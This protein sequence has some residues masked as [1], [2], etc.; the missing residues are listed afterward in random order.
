VLQALFSSRVRVRAL[1]IFLLNPDTS[2]HT[3]ALAQTVGA[4]YSAVW[5]ELN[6]LEQAGLLLSESSAHTKAYRVNPRCPILP[7]LRAMILKTVGAGDTLRQAFTDLGA[8][9]TAFI[10][11]SFAAGDPDRQSDLDVMMIGNVKLTRLAPVFARL[12]KDLGRAVNYVCYTPEEWTE[13]QRAWE[14]FV[15]NVLAGPKIMLIG[16]ED[17]LRATRTTR[18]HQA[19]PSAPRRNPSV[20]KGRRAR[21]RRR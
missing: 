5:K 11:G 16:D 2:F 9:D 1:T 7:E 15:T 4:Q 17:A 18:T 20:A 14:P 10:Y 8:I 12:E 13:K 6:N 19:L 3:R 21:S